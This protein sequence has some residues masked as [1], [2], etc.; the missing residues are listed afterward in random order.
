M[1]TSSATGSEQEADV[2]RVRVIAATVEGKKSRPIELILDSG[3]YGSLAPSWMKSFGRKAPAAAKQTLR[4]ATGGNITVQDSRVIEVILQDSRG[5][6][7]KIGEVFLMATVINPLLAVGRLFPRRWQLSRNS[8]G[9][10]FLEDQESSFPT[11]YKRNSLATTACVRAIH[12]SGPVGQASI[13]AHL[14]T[15]FKELVEA[16]YPG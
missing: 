6:Q 13:P 7:V 1:S 11:H 4:D 15:F 12:S 16:G 14:C 10:M 8:E 2:Q 3:A 5:N 9:S